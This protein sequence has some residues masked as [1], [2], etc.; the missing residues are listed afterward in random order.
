M[1]FDNDKTFCQDSF[2]NGCDEKLCR[3]NCCNC[4]DTTKPQSYAK[5]NNTDE[6]LK[7]KLKN[8]TSILNLAMFDTENDLQTLTGL[9]HQELWN[10]GFDLDDWDVGFQTNEPMSE[11]WLL[12]RLISYCS[13][14]K[15]VKYND[16]YYYLAYRS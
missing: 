3:L 11:G 15:Q 9:S 7:T 2:I 13:G 1:L 8:K 5:F 14:Y 12:N 10:A 16:K 4:S 6:C